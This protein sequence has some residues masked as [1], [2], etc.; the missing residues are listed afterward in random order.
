VRGKVIVGDAVALGRIGTFDLVCCVEVAEHVPPASS[1]GLVETICANAGRWIYFTAA[2]PFQ[3]GHGH[4]NCRQQFFWLNQFRKL[5]V[6][7]DW[8]MTERFLARIDDLRPAVWLPMN[9][10]VLR[11]I[12]AAA[13]VAVPPTT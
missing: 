10:L 1:T 5:G 3:P 11:R 7:I 8:D 2:S 12:G 4:I 9:S 13:P 6:E